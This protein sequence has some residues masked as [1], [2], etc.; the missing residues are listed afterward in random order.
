MACP[1]L[2]PPL[3]TSRSAFARPTPRRCD[4][5]GTW[6]GR[7]GHGRRFIVRTGSGIERE[8]VLPDMPREPE[9]DVT[10][11][12]LEGDLGVIRIS[13]FAERASV[14]RFDA[15]LAALEEA[16]GLIIDVRRNG[17]GDTAV[18][19]P[20]MGRFIA[21]RRPYAR[22]R[23][24][25]GVGLSPAWT[26]YVDPRGPFTFTRP[27][28]VLADFWSGSMAEGFPMGMRAIAGA[29]FVGT[30]MARLGA[31]V[32]GLRLD[33]T[34]LSA[35]YSGEPVY[36]IHNVPRSSLKPGQDLLRAGISELGRLISRE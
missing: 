36:D 24:R 21:E 3:P 33:R 14:E 12:T 26:E 9:A 34:G 10:C 22:M 8:V 35:Q 15:A 23:R 27:V 16:R 29:R 1:S 2:P 6:P 18:A 7:R 31:A 30:P 19:R 13:I 25:D 28:V 17:G 11:R 32:F 5:P 4:T 20:I